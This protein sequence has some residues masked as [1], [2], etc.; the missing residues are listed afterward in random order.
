MTSKNGSLIFV[1]SGV[2]DVAHFT[3]QAVAYLHEA[4]RVHYLVPEPAAQIYIQQ[5]SLH[6]SNLAQYYQEGKS[7]YES[8]LEMSEVI[9]RD[10]R[11]GHKVVVIIKGHPGS[12]ASP[13]HRALAMAREEGYKAKMLPGISPL[14]S[15]IAD[16]EIDPSMYGCMIS[17]ATE[18]LAHDRPLDTSVHNIILHI[19]Y[20]GEQLDNS[21]FSLLVNRLTSDFDSEHRVTH[22]LG[23]TTPQSRLAMVT[24]SIA[25]LSAES[26][27]EWILPQSALYIPPLAVPKPTAATTLG[28]PDIVTRYLSASTQCE[29]ADGSSSRPS[30]IVDYGDHVKIALERVKSRVTSEGFQSMRASTAMRDF[31]TKL[32]LRCSFRDDYHDSEEKRAELLSRVSGLTDRERFALQFALAAPVEALIFRDT[33]EEQSEEQLREI[34]ARRPRVYLHPPMAV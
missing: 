15:M 25:E 31:L 7:R 21:R 6:T 18:L 13:A 2:V 26:L 34:A 4:E 11:A 22:Y 1:G 33:E 12:S 8:Y 30:T 24:Y 3:L 5:R 10:V 32:S 19:G 14:D 27:A 16:L 9:M 29:S 17:E 20:I 28:L 23:E